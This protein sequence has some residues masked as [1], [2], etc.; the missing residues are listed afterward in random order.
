MRNCRA[1]RADRGGIHLLDL[2]SS[3]SRSH[4]SGYSLVKFAA[5]PARP[6]FD[7]PVGPVARSP[8]SRICWRADHLALLVHHLVVLEDVLADL[9]VAV[10]DG[11]LRA[12]MALVTILASSA[13]R[14]GTPCP[15]PSSSPRSRT[16]V[17]GRPR[18]TG[19]SG[20]P[21]SPCRTDRPRSWLSMRRLVTLGAEDEEATA[22]RTRAVGRAL[23]RSARAAP[24]TSPATLDRATAGEH[25][26]ER[27]AFGVAAEED[28]DTTA[29]HAG[30][31]GHRRSAL[32]ARRRALPA[33]AARASA[34]VLIPRF[35]SSRDRCSDFD[36]DRA[37][38]HRLTLRP[39]MM[40]SAA[41]SNFAASPCR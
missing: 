23:S 4:S 17:R 39:L 38:E 35:S 24:G 30:G 13:R 1:A 20:S 37:D 34:P 22:S 12:L 15:S 7:R 33:R 2:P 27:E 6:S 10:F 18:A 25:L 16:G 41:A 36:R 32:P 8:P 9:E 31:D 19:R 26:L 5:R 28:V 11:A 21:G 3:S 14:R 29:G 40:S